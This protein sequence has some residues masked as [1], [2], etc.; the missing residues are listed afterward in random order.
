MGLKL[1][2]NVKNKQASLRKVILALVP[3]PGIFSALREFRL[4][5][6]ASPSPPRGA[7]GRLSSL[8]IATPGATVLGK[9]AM[10]R[11]EEGK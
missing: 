11:V 10:V 6:Q 8:L 4:M 7:R 9:R 5:P 2:K 1:R 3:V